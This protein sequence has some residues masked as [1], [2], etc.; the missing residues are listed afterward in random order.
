[1]A[2]FLLGLADL[3]LHDQNFQGP[4]TGRRWKMYR[5]FFQD[6][7][8]VSPNLTL[9]LGLA[10][11]VVTP[12][13]EEANRQ[14]NFN[15]QTGQWLIAGK[16]A[17]PGVGIATDLSAFEPRIGIAWSPRGD[18]KTAVRLG[19]SIYHDSSWN[20]GG[21]GLW[22]NPPYWAESANGSFFNDGTVTPAQGYSISQ[23]FLPLL[24]EP[25]SPSQFGG[26]INAE[27]LNFKQGRIQQFN[28]NIE[29]QLP[30]DV[31]LTLGYAGA[32]SSHLLTDDFNVNLTSPTACG[33]VAGY[34]L[35]CGAPPTPWPN[36][37]F[38]YDVFD[39]GHSRYDSLQ[40]RAETKSSHGLYALVSYTYSKNFDSGMPDGLGSNIGAL[41]YPLPGAATMDKGFS[42]I[43]LTHNFTASVVYGLPFG[44]GKH[45]GNDWGGVTNGLFGGWEVTVIEHA[46]SGFPLFIQD[47]NN[48]SGVNFQ[49]NGLALNR[50]NR[51]CNGRL[52]NWTVSE[53]FNTSCFV[54]APVITQAGVNYGELGNS[55][56]TPL[57][58]PP[59]VNT[60]FSAIKNIRLPIRE[61]TSLQF[62]AEFFNLWNHP[63]FATPTPD[64]GAG[65]LFGVINQSVNNPR[66]IQFALKLIF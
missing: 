37:G 28:L 36:F 12:I 34:T 4:V 55:D 9:N 40:V 59:F 14:S 25:T 63:Q 8:R 61:G 49:W 52:S 54:P 43:N 3:A 30:G 33:N 66:L 21:Q 11:A 5:P 29:R 15:F 13:S 35:G 24:T 38:I 10:W 31:L 26:N 51:V 22:Q 27:N 45:W 42:Q 44:K 18:R 1:M 32:R 57:F 58:G 17:G 48:T 56:R 7:W 19:Y 46:I 50:P 62:R 20:Q 39:N 16:G 41:Y 53:F 64:L 23:G 6:N 60:D 2:D 65:P 47:S